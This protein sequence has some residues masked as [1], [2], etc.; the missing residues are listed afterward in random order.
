[1]NENVTKKDLQERFMQ[2]KREQTDRFEQFKTAQDDVLAQK[3]MEN[4]HNTPLGK[5]LGIIATLP[6]IRAEKVEH[7]RQLLRRKSLILMS[8][9]MKRWIAFW[10]NCC[11]ITL[12]AVVQAG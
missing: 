12:S 4:I 5:L 3:I 9:S 8:S 11:T 1:M 7:G 2:A 10:R 6:E